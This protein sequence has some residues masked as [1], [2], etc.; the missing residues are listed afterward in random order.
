MSQTFLYRTDEFP[1]IPS[2]RVNISN[3][4]G[5]AILYDLDVSV[6]SGAARTIIPESMLK[7]LSS[8]SIGVRELEGIGGF[9]IQLDIHQ[10][11]VIIHGFAAVVVEVAADPFES[12]ILLGRDVMNEHAMLLDGPNGR[13]EIL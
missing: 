9:K 6:D 8:T 10:I 11:W 7:Q 2:V 12:N 1:A 5:S 3:L 13:V 4:D